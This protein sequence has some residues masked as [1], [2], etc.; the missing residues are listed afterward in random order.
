MNWNEF[1]ANYYKANGTTSRQVLS[2]EYNYYKNK[3][4][5]QNSIIRKKSPS[6]KRTIIR[7]PVRSRSPLRSNKKMTLKD[8]ENLAKGQ[9]FVIIVIWAKWCGH[10]DQMKKRLG[11]KMKDTQKI[12]FIE[13]NNLDDS[14]KEYFP[15]ILYYQDGQRQKDLTVDDVY[16]YLGA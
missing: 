8:I 1:R 13:E 10:C 16:T 3:L 2:Q 4:S 14:L 6:P 12:I 5:K 7:S 15:R 9:R 11:N